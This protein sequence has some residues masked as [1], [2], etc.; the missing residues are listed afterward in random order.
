MTLQMNAKEILTVHKIKH[1]L[2]TSV[3]T[4]AKRFCVAIEQHVRQNPIGL[5]V[6][7]PSGCRAIRQWVALKQA[8]D[9]IMIVKTTKNVSSLLKIVSLSVQIILVLKVH[10]ALRVI[11]K[12]SACVTIHLK[13]MGTLPVMSQ[14]SLVFKQSINNIPTILN[15]ETIE[16]E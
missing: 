6:L 5:F 8:V 11:T 13:E 10:P 12:S 15:D 1:V 9:L 3:V 7:A 4:L 16:Q 2:R 14:V